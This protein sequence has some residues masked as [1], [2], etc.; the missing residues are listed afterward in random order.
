MWEQIKKLLGLSMASPMPSTG[1]T[2][3]PK[4]EYI[5]EG[6]KLIDP[7]TGT[8]KWIAEPTATPQPT[9][10]GAVLGA[11][12]TQATPYETYQPGQPNYMDFTA[13]YNGNSS[14]PIPQPPKELADKLFAQRPN[15]AT[16]AATLAFSENL[17]YDPWAI[18]DKN[19]DGSTDYGGFQNNDKTLRLLLGA[20]QYANMLQQ[21]GISQPQDVLGDWDKAIAALGQTRVFEETPYPMGAGNLPYSQWYGWQDRGYNP[22]PETSL[23]DLAQQKTP[24]GRYAYGHLRDYLGL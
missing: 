18:N 22:M 14:L 6:N 15:D 12:T 11:L 8:W 1:S 4:K 3:P 20:N 5:T 21:A 13:G 17:R 19:S 24:A 2:I 7:K 10:P 9:P 16:S 23:S